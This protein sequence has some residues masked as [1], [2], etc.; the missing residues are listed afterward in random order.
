LVTKVCN[1]CK[2]ESNAFLVFFKP[3]GWIKHRTPD[4]I[5]M[6]FCSLACFNAFKGLEPTDRSRQA[7]KPI[8]VQEEQLLATIAR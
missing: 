3:R 5:D 2:I 1:W 4:G 7:K 8:E 6:L